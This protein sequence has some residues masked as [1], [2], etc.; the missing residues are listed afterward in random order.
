[1]A[2]RH[3]YGKIAGADA[4]VFAYDT[5][6]TRNSYKGEPTENLF[7]TTA[8]TFGSDNPTYTPHIENGT[9][10]VG[11]YIIKDTVNAPWWSGLRVNQNGVNPLTA[12]VSYVVSFECRSPQYDWSWGLDA[13]AS[14]GGW[15]GNDLG[16]AS[17]TN[18]VFDKTG[19]TVYTSDMLN[20]WQRVSYRVTMKDA[21][22][23]TGAS[24]YPHDSFFPNQN[25][26]KVYYRNPQIEVG[27]TRATQYVNGARSATQGLLDL[28]GNSTIDLSNVS[29]NSSANIEFDGSNDNF[30]VNVDSVIRGYTAVTFESVHRDTSGTGGATPYSL[31]TSPN[32][33]NEADGFWHHWVLGGQWYWRLEDNVR[34]EVGGIFSGATPF[35]TGNWYHVVAVV[36]TNTIL[37]YLNGTLLHTVNTSFAWAN[38]RTDSTAYLYLGSGYGDNYYFAGNLPVFKMYNKELTADEV[39]N[40]YRHYK[41]RFDI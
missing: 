36:K 37:Y 22:T 1:V 38:L 39:R 29:F 5:G 32:T 27:K 13:N 19:G 8:M 23:F 4:L 7:G 12:G 9:D 33:S 14:G 41:T 21:T 18:L 24:A 17:N 3:G 6:D 40:N 31:L 20:T 16:R 28:T 25:N 11:N 2:V 35:Q 15:S 30:T 10:S 34:G 26:I